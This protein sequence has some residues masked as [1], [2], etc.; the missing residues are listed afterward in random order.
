MM[1]L[2]RNEI[3][4]ILP[5]AFDTEVADLQAK[6]LTFRLANLIH[7][8]GKTFGNELLEPNLQPRLQEIL[9]PLKAMLN[10]DRSMAEALASFIHRLQERLFT[11]RRESFDGKVMAAVIELHEEGTDITSQN[12]ADHISQTDDEAAELSA[13]KVGRITKKLGFI[14]DRVGKER[15]R[16]LRWNEERVVRLVSLYGFKLQP[17]LSQPEVV[18]VSLVSATDTKQA[19]TIN[20]S[21]AECPPKCPPNSEASPHV[22]ADTKDGTDTILD[23]ANHTMFLSEL[24]M[25]VQEALALWREEGK[26]VINLG[27]GENCLDLEKLL[28]RRDINERHL[29]AVRDWLE[30]RRR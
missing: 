18:K 16:I 15:Q 23:K 21:L 10:G 5:P 17:S 1:P 24:G 6:L 25:T 13:D 30:K 7:L 11:R 3:P 8:K 29:A 4:R 20:P 9:I 2:T 22:K 27:P 12:I 19:D 28:S 14:K 26:P